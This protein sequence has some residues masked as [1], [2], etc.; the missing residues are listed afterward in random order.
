MRGPI[1]GTAYHYEGEEKRGSEVNQRVEEQKLIFSTNNNFERKY[2]RGLFTQS[3]VPVLIRVTSVMY[4]R[5]KFSSTG[6]L[7]RARMKPV[8][9]AVKHAETCETM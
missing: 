2:F 6:E 5:G 4:Y 3:R 8:M 1:T 7:P 9:H